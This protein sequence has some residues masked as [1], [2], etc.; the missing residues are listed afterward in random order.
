MPAR[1]ARS[2]NESG[3]HCVNIFF[4]AQS[5]ERA[6]S[7]SGKQLVLISGCNSFPQGVEKV[8]TSVCANYT[9]PLRMRVTA[10]ITKPYQ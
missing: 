8:K 10:M 4:T 1:Y 9:Y 7:A 5:G 3:L 6:R 2:T